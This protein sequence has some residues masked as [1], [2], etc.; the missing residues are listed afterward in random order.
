MSFVRSGV[1]ESSMATR[2][3]TQGYWA[4]LTLWQHTLKAPMIERV[5]TGIAVV[6]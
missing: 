2:S 4:V 6:Q 3:K 5:D 1:V